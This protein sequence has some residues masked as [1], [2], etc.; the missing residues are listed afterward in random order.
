M[1]SRFKY[2]SGLDP[3]TEGRIAEI[4]GEDRE[5]RGEP[6]RGPAVITR[7]ATLA[8]L[9]RFD[10]RHRM[11]PATSPTL[12]T[13]PT[14]RPIATKSTGEAVKDSSPPPAALA[15]PAPAIDELIA[16]GFGIA[17]SE[18]N[19]LRAPRPLVS[20]RPDGYLRLNRYASDALGTFT[21]LYLLVDMSAR[22]LAVVV[23][24]LDQATAVGSALRKATCGLTETVV[25]AREELSELG[26]LGLR[27][28]QFRPSRVERGLIVVDVVADELVTP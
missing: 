23:G 12:P 10:Q 18:R 25:L 14:R 2:A 27:T 7:R 26:M 15:R 5:R 11:P 3:A 8:E 17:E 13:L 19:R 22:R 21:H 6:A 24:T 20:S 1:A 9:A 16:E 4:V 28:R